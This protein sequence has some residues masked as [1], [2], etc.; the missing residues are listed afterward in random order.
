MIRPA[1]ADDLPSLLALGERMHAESPRFSRLRF[2][3][4][5]LRSTL[6]SLIGSDSGFLW[7]AENA[8]G[9]LTGGMA[10]VVVQHWAS[11]DLVATDLALF[12]DPSARGSL[13][14]LRLLTRYRQWAAERGA[15]LIQVGVTTGV[16]TETTARLYEQLGFSRCGVILEA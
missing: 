4:D 13:A 8:A 12:M 16:D 6:S 3:A 14:P 11:S 15:K 1:T 7:V 2:D 5:R 9:N 10:A